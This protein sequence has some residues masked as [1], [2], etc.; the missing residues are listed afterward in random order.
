MNAVPMCHLSDG[1]VYFVQHLST[2]RIVGDTVQTNLPVA[3]Y[4]SHLVL[5]VL[6]PISM[7]STKL[8]DVELAMP[9]TTSFLHRDFPFVPSL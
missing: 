9:T 5:S 7:L 6:V 1:T 8:A 4:R 2:I 3:E